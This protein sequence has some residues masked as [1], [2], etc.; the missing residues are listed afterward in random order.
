VSIPRRLFRIAVDK[1]RE[2]IDEGLDWIPGSSPPRKDARQ[3]LDEFLADPAPPAAS[4]RPPG[5]AP[6]PLAAEYQLLGLA[7]GADRDAVRRAWRRL[8]RDHHPDRHAGDPPAQ[9][10]ARERFLIYQAAYERIIASLD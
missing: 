3:E 8:V 7:P 4:R 2:G 5:P 1:L 9:A 10:A 6:H